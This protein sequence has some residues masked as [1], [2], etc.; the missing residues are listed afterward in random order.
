MFSLTQQATSNVAEQSGSADLIIIQPDQDGSVT[1]THESST[2]SEP[3][4]VAQ[5]EVV[6]TESTTDVVVTHDADHSTVAVED[7]HATVEVPGAPEHAVGMPQ[8]DTGYYGNLIFWL[9]LTLAILYWILSRVALPR[10][11]GIISD[12]QGAITGD[13]MAAEELK[14]KAK[15][16]EAAYDRALAEARTEAQ[17]IVAANRADIQ[18][19]LDKAIAHADAEIAARSAESEKRISGIRASAVEDARTVAKDVT[20]ELL[21]HFGGNADGAA[22]DA[23]VD[24]RLKGVTQ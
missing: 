3:V 1:V 14:Q 17:K 7:T 22:I 4:I 20:A 11:S 23:A 5:D 10:I 12:R 9:L 6:T 16:A 18:K 24:A 2:G 19:D 13:L 8:L 21:R 15:D